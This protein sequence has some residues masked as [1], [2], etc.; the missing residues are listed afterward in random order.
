MLQSVEDQLVS[1]KI[2][3]EQALL[4]RILKSQHELHAMPFLTA[5]WFTEPVHKRI[6]SAMRQKAEH[7]E[8]INAV[9]LK[10]LFDSDPAL[11]DIGGGK[12][13]FNLLSQAMYAV[14]A[15]DIAREIGDIKSRFEL[16]EFCKSAIADCMDIN[17]VAF[18]EILMNLTGNA[19]AMMEGHGSRKIK[20]EYEVVE[21]LLDD[22]KA[23]PKIYSTGINTLDTAMGGGLHAGKAYGIAARK[24]VGKTVLAGTISYNLAQNGV[25]H[26][27]VCG[28]MGEKEIEQRI[29]ARRTGSFSS[30]FNNTY[31][32]SRDFTN[33]LAETAVNLR[34]NPSAMF[35]D[36]PGISFNELKSVL[37]EAV[38]KHKITGFI[39]DYWQL[40]GGKPK[41]KS[42]SEHLDEVAQW[43]AEFGRKYGVW[44][45]TMAQINQ[46]GNTRGG[47]GMRLAFD[48]VYQLHRDDVTLPGAWMEMMDTRYTKW[49]DIGGKDDPGLIM[50]ETPHFESV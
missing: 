14:S 47:E 26:L 23:D 2:Q 45:V 33:K 44:S 40:V 19:I 38:F 16:V 36:A 6:F 43:I 18:S 12:Y 11:I 20:Q 15:D 25:K 7:G 8:E 3:L 49:M 31:G 37:L 13:I 4:G 28:E 5:D 9:T 46:E 35:Y 24:K 22:L 29:S 10:P 21:S 1:S 34:N 41:S 32:R 27:F 48:Q 42:T 39:L 50:T 17:S 30:A